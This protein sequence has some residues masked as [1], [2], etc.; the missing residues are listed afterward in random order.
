VSVAA[1]IKAC[2]KAPGDA[3]ALIAHALVYFDDARAQSA[4]DQ[5]LPAEN[6][7]ALRAYARDHG[8]KPFPPAP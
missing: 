4:A 5:F 6:A 2:Q 8:D 1:I 3:A 7:R